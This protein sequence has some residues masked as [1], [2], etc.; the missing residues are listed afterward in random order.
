MRAKIRD[1]DTIALV[2]FR[3]L[4]AETSLTEVAMQPDVLPNK[5]GAPQLA[6][7]IHL[8]IQGEKFQLQT[9]RC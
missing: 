1:L 2:P 3:I 8:A 6:A 5:V 7:R 4:A 9:R